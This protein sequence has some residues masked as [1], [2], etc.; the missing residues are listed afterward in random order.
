M[1]QDTL[2]PEFYRQVEKADHIVFS[3]FDGT[4]TLQ[5]S[6]DFL[7]DTLG[8]GYETRKGL[9]DEILYKKTSFRDGFQQMLDSVH[10]PWP[11]CIEYLKNHID[12]DTGFKDFYEWCLA[13]NVLVVIV[14]SGM[15][16]IIHNLLVKLLNGEDNVY[17]QH[18]LE[19]IANDV[20]ITDEQKQSWD[21]VYRDT[22]DFGHDKSIEIKKIIN[23]KNS[24]AAS[25]NQSHKVHYFYCGDGV[26]DLSA[27]RESELLFAK[28]GKDLIKYC[29][30]EKI[31]YTTFQS[32]KDIHQKVESILSGQSTIDSFNELGK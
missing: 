21:I 2:S 30:A 32:F 8:M 7:T 11:E 4:I 6:N 26:S 10:T 27:A 14:S 13:H 25:K 5:D 29:E 15:K 20:K 19:I 28:S 17:N 23:Y 16:P 22:T 12:L 9:N 24:F 3:D 1:T 18:P 31:P